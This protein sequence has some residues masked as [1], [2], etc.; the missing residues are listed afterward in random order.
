MRTIETKVFDF[1]ELSNEAKETAI[2]NVRNDFYGYNNFAE[3]AI[4]DCSL[5]EPPNKELEELFGKNY[6]F[7]L[8]KNN[9]KVYFSLDRNRH[10]DISNAMEVTNDNQFLKWLRVDHIDNLEYSIGE[11]TIEF[12]NYPSQY[13]DVID[14]AVEKFEEH[15]EDILNRIKANI[16]YRFSDEAI[17]EDIE[18]NGCEFLENGELFN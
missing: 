1:D 4:D 6:D 16:D 11:D 10:I 5:L 15:C 18:C 2:E 12:D 17:I 13:G 9:R 7:P 8:L 14:S 3:W